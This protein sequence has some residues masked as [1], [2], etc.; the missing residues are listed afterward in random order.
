[1]RR[2]A[3][4]DTALALNLAFGEPPT[5]IHPVVWFGRL[6]TLLERRARRT[7]PAAELSSGVVLVLLTLLVAWQVA[8]QAERLA[9]S[10]GRRLAQTATPRPGPQRSAL[11]AT[12]ATLLVEGWLMKTMLPLR[13]LTAAA[14]AVQQALDHDDLPAAR[15]A[16]HSLVSRDVAALDGP[17]LAAATIESLA[18]NAGDSLVA[19]T[20]AYLA[21]GLPGAA[22]YRGINTLDAMFGY[23]GVNEWFGKAA[24]RLDDAANL[25]PARL[26]ACLLSV[27]GSFNGRAKATWRMARRDHQQ[28]ASPNAGWPMSA[29]A[30]ALGVELE[31]IGNYRLGAP[32]AVRRHWNGY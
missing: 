24:A 26:T 19:P 5:A 32:A 1:M 28:T 2:S 7:T 17:L 12:A 4:M 14:E 31:K 27:A 29:M 3:V 30:G 21:F 9:A 10:G 25:V 18:E 22:L 15:T 20:L 23:R 13:G 8:R 16:L 6:A 11:L